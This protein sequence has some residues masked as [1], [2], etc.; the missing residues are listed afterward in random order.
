MIVIDIGHGWRPT[1]KTMVFDPGAVGELDGK[2]Y[3]EHTIASWYAESLRNALLALD[4]DLTVALLRAT[5]SN[6]LNLTKRREFQPNARAFI[7]IHLNASANTV[8]TGSEVWYYRE[9]HRSLAESVARACKSSLDL[10]HRGIKRKS[11]AVLK[12]LSTSVLVELGFITNKSDLQLL[13]L[14]TTRLAWCR[15]AASAIWNWM[16]T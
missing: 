2:R 13:L 5:K 6:P 4:P 10:P 1:G 9:S 16:K 7:S 12:R 15:A 14:Q 8:A 11:F 3:F